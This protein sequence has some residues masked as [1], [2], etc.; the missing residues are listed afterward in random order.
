MIQYGTSSPSKR[1]R[2]IRQVPSPPAYPLELCAIS[3]ESLTTIHPL[4][5]MA[6]VEG[7]VALRM[8]RS[9]TRSVRNSG[10]GKVCFSDFQNPSTSQAKTIGT[11]LLLLFKIES[12]GLARRCVTDARSTDCQQ[13]S[14]TLH[15]P[16]IYEDTREAGG[17]VPSSSSSSQPTH[18]VCESS[19]V[20]TSGSRSRWAPRDR[21][22]VTISF[23]RRC[24]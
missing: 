16:E 2:S 11:P 3:R 7:K 6:S 24:D 9:P 19:G 5:C 13:A 17:D 22:T 21:W 14:G 23:G 8:R 10:S 12:A 1:I 20:R 18:S 15:P 4:W